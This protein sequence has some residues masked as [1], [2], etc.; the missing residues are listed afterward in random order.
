MIN[1]F[2]GALL[3]SIWC[4]TLFYGK[5]I[6]LS[7]L[8][9]VVPLTYYII[10]ILE[11][12]NK[13]EDSKAKVLILPITLLAS[14]YFLFNNMF[15][16]T[17]NIIVIPTLIVIMILGLFKEKFELNIE[18]LN[19]IFDIFFTPISFVGET[20]GKLTNY[21]KGKCKRKIDCQKEHKIK[22][23]IKSIFITI[24]I[25]FIIIALLSSADEIFGDIFINIFQWIITAIG[26]INISS[27]FVRILMIF[28]TFTYLMCFFDFITSRY[29][30]KE[31]VEKQ[32]K[33]KD[34]FTIKMILT[35]LNVV[36][37]LF[38]YIQ[39]KSLFMRN[40]EI[41]YAQYARE[42]FFQL[43]IV[44]VINLITI[45]IAK[46]NENI[47]NNKENK[48]I[49]TMCILMIGLT[50]IILVSSAV[51]MYFYESA[52][53][54]TILRLLV[55]VVLATEAILLIPTIM[56]VL[57]K[58]INLAKTYFV[59]ILSAYVVTNMANINSI[60]T[61]R[62]VDRYLE[63]GKIDFYYL[64]NEIGIDCILEIPEILEIE[65]AVGHE[66][67]HTDIRKYVYEEITELEKEPFD[68]RD[69]NISKMLVKNM[70]K[71]D[72]KNITIEEI[73]KYGEEIKNKEMLP[74]TVIAKVDGENIYKYDLDRRQYLIDKSEEKNQ[75]ALYEVIEEKILIKYQDEDY[76]DNRQN[77]YNNTVNQ[78][79]NMTVEEFQYMLDMYGISEDE[80]WISD[81]ALKKLMLQQSLDMYRY[82]SGYSKILEN[83]IKN[84]DYFMD[85]NY[86]EKLEQYN[87]STELGEKAQLLK[88]IQDIYIEQLVLTSNIEFCSYVENSNIT[89]N[90]VTEYSQEEIILSMQKGE[91]FAKL[92]DIAI[93]A[94]DFDEIIYMFN[95]KENS[96]KKL[97]HSKDGISKIYFDG[98]YVYLLPSYYRGKGIIKIDLLGNAKKIYEGASI[99]LWIDED[100]I[101]FTDQIGYDSINGTPQGNLCAMNKDGTNKQ[102]LIEN[103][104][105][106]FYIVD[107]YIYYTDQGSR[108]IYRANID[109]TNKNEIATGR[110]YITSVTDKY[111]TYL[112]Y[113]N[114]EKHRIIYFDNNQNNV[115]GKF[116]NVYH[117]ESET[118]FYTKRL[119]NTN[120]VE[121]N[122]TLFSVNE[123]NKNETALWS[124]NENTFDYL[125]YIYN[126]FGYFRRGSEFYKVNIRDNH[127]EKMDFGSGTYFIDGKAYGVKSKDGNIEELCIYNLDD[128]SREVI[129]SSED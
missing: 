15:F 67:L 107:D 16:N 25:L 66:D 93:Y 32:K 101:Y 90:T 48:Y 64:K 12:N 77:L 23:V 83:C 46:K 35:S 69:F 57:D 60:I 58:N 50:F 3:L 89:N 99:Q 4:V 36:Y 19:K 92:G 37:V 17:I 94:N 117:S 72:S 128:M 52:Y 96:F 95:I 8:L 31:E 126:D 118:Y 56:Y 6:G 40:V 129:N 26:K 14:T 62:N 61:K 103:V 44:S 97:Y 88:E 24:P 119:I 108:S 41:N 78:Y 51:R 11:K 59:I 21:L 109:G 102:V 91:H 42:G 114:G 65:E 125:A 20:F 86:L 28:L 80:K 110:T 45:L 82:N 33:S 121:N 112:D 84:E 81:E 127:D 27:I 1:I 53:G 79:E 113:N 30:K 2:I 18:L 123:E 68:F 10:H 111:L 74:N 63:T 5:S 76:F 71:Y 7:M 115:V 13:I 22:R 39:I 38:C 106:Y 49:N 104:K 100:E 122:L 116:G 98:K 105:N 55:Y 70:K 85:R 43:M 87:N 75:N 124:S 47:E 73:Q 34:N 9:F 29:R 54:Y 120:N